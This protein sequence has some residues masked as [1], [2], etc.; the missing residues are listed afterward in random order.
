MAALIATCG[1]G[2][3]L[4]A[5]IGWQYDDPNREDG[6]FPPSRGGRNPFDDTDR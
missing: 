3:A 6:F 4:V 2:A 1:S 5:F